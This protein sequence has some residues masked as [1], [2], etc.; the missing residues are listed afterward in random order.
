MENIQ[1]EVTE[2]N[3]CEYRF[4]RTTLALVQFSKSQDSDPRINRNGFQLK[5][6]LRL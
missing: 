6:P 2:K 3:D 1:H 5:L 4:E